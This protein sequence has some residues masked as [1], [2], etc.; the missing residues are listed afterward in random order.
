[1]FFEIDHNSPQKSR[2]LSIFLKDIVPTGVLLNQ[3]YYFKISIYYFDLT[4]ILAVTMPNH[5]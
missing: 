2:F 1:M 5:V 4:D 3:H